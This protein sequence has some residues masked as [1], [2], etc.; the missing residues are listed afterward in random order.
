[1]PSRVSAVSTDSVDPAS[2]LAYWE[3]Y[4]SRELV[5]FRCSTYRD[6]GLRAK[7]KN[8]DLGGPRLASIEGNP[9]VV[10]RSVQQV[11]TSP[12]DSIFVTVLT[13]GTAFFHHPRGLLTLKAGDAIVYEAGKPYLFGFDTDMRQLLIDLPRGNDHTVPDQPL[14]LRAGT[15]A[16][17]ARVQALTVLAEELLAEITEPEKS[18]EDLITTALSLFQ[19]TETTSAALRRTVKALIDTRLTDPDLNAELVAR[20]V[21]IS[22]RHLN[23]AFDEERTTVSR[24]IHGQRL[25]MAHAELTASDVPKIADLAAKWGF[26]SQPHF[27]RAFR[28][29]YE[30]TPSEMRALS[31]EINAVEGETARTSTPLDE[32]HSATNTRPAG[33]RNFA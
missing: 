12:T 13:K 19:R 6:D 17:S 18:S 2:R 23:R 33:A 21:G 26:S 16:E 25:E 27:T 28:R 20:S 11:K 3:D 22:L 8:L 10:D 4:N 7:E 1:V 30:M 24:Y 5:G 15:G 9:H 14:L 32:P 29:R 31:V